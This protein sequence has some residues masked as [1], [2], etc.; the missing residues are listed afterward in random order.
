MMRKRWVIKR[1][2][3]AL[4]QKLQKEL[5]VSSILAQLLI[6]RDLTS[7][8]EIERFLSCQKSLLYDPFTLQGMR[9][10]VSRIRTAIAAREKILIYGDYDA[11]GI[12]AACVLITFLKQEGADVSSYIPHRIDEGYGLNMEAVRFARSQGTSLVIAVDCGTTDKEEVAYLNRYGIDTIIIDHHQVR[13]ELFP[14]AYSLINPLQPG[15]GYPF[16][17]LAAVGLAYKVVCAL[18][19]DA[20][21][22]GDEYLDLVAV[23]TVA[24]VVPL[25]GENRI[26]TRHGLARLRTTARV[27]L[28]ALMEAAGIYGRN[29][30]TE[31]IGF[32]IGPRINVSGR[33]GSA[34]LALRLLLTEDADEAR[35]ISGILNQE[36]STRQRMQ[37]EIFKEALS[38][39]EGQVNFKDHQVIVVWGHGWHPGVVGIVASKI[40]DRFYRPAIV[41]GVKEKIAKG[42]GRSIDNFHLFEAVHRCRALVE[43]FGGHEAAC[44]LTILTDNLERFR[45]SINTVAR[46]MLSADDLVPKVDVEMEMPLHLVKKEIIKD[47]ERLSPYGMGNPQPLF[48]STGVRLKDAPTRFG[49]NGMRMWV[50]DKKMTCE[51]VCF[52]AYDLGA[53]PDAGALDLVYYPKIRKISG[54]D[55]VELEVEDLKPSMGGN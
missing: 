43:N 6:N 19:G 14:D 30:Q 1:P 45:D 48:L 55:S 50:T 20:G 53:F 3:Q 28:K 5:G 54:I 41:L 51:A 16:K 4:Q 32:I 38:H 2:D 13:G 42:S 22:A 9:K 44:G 24:D 52:N 10:A 34:D 21:N 8:S 29:I 46:Q 25:V 15:C 33:I 36:N 49:K 12:T 7:L 40:V 27:G 17:D 31:H 47:L 37:E 35:Q 26:L 11:D 23:G 18:S 39:I